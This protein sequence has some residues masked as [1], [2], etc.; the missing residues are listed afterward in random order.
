MKK[1]LLLIN[2]M[3]SIII[4]F[5]SC[6]KGETGSAGQAGPQGPTGGYL[7]HQIGESYGGGIVFYVYDNGQHG[8]VTAAVDQSTAIQWFNGIYKNTGARDDG[9]GTGAINTAI[10]VA[11]QIPDN[12]AGSFAAKVCMNYSFTSGTVQYNDW[13][14][15]SK[16]E[17]NLLYLQKDTLG[18]FNGN[19]YWSSTE[20]DANSAWYQDF[21]SGVQLA[22]FKNNV[23]NVRAI[24]SF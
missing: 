19:Y 24:R 4:S 12:N 23:S 13:Y 3:F 1:K 17:L 8:L 9:F 6:E 22:T 21:V 2:L 11:A 7:S 18:G 5:S 10:I 16:Y 20:N 15:P 14:L